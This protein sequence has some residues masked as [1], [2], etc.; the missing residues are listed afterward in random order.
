[1]GAQ[2]EAWDLKILKNQGQGSKGIKLSGR[3]KAIPQGLELSPL[4][5]SQ[6]LA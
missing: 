4:W 3:L 5:I 1:M 2:I 6:T